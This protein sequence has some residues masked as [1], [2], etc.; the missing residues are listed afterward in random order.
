MFNSIINF[1]S[2]LFDNT[3]DEL[4][5]LRE[6]LINILIATI[7]GVIAILAF[8]PSMEKCVWIT[9]IPW[10][11][12]AYYLFS[13]Q[14]FIR[15][16]ITGEMLELLHVSVTNLAKAAAVITATGTTT[17]ASATPAPA[18]APATTGILDNPFIKIYLNVISKIFLAQTALFLIL[19]LYVNYTFGGKTT[20][21]II[22][23]LMVIIAIDNF[24]SFTK[25]SRFTVKIAVIA[26]A[27]GLIF[28]LFPHVGFYLTGITGSAKVVSASTAKRVNDL[29]ALQREQ[30]EKIDNDFVDGVIAWQKANPGAKL[31]KEYKEAFNRARKLGM[32]KSSS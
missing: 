30:Q 32:L 27:V 31:P 8:E 6:C 29:N 7:V 1:F 24:T 23:M 28:V 25:L 19:P 20:A 14:R 16:H 21:I 22:L 3:V 15:M 2:D 4:A 11:V 5:K 12:S 17:T 13:I 10:V 9:L 26:Y 18:A